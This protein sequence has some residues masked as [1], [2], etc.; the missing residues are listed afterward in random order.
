MQGCRSRAYLDPVGQIWPAFSAFAEFVPALTDPPREKP[1]RLLAKF[2]LGRYLA[3]L[4]PFRMFVDGNLDVIRRWIAEG[5]LSLAGHLLELQIKHRE[6]VSRFEESPSFNPFIDEENLVPLCAELAASCRAALFQG[7]L[8]DSI[9]DLA[10]LRAVL[11][12]SKD[13]W[14]D[15]CRQKLDELLD[16]PAQLDRFV[17]YCYGEEEPGIGNVRWL[18]ADRQLLRTR[19][20]QRLESRASAMPEQVRSAYIN[21]RSRTLYLDNGAP[22]PPTRIESTAV[23]NDNGRST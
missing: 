15:N 14:D 9:A 5:H 13:G 22:Q 19:V 20:N 11:T 21:A 17:W 18:I 6:L 12:G 3:S 10:C 1:N 16:Q 4:G 23:N 7:R 2:L 8:I